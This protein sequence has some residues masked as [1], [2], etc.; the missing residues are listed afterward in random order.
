MLRSQ[1]TSMLKNKIHELAN[2]LSSNT[3]NDAG[4]SCNLPKL[5][6]ILKKYIH[7]NYI[8]AIQ[9]YHIFAKTHT[10]HCGIHFSFNVIKITKEC[11]DTQICNI[12]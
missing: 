4:R 6:P 1:E 2:K 8:T 5:M 7:R 11:T 3:Q 10:Q 9:F 12:V